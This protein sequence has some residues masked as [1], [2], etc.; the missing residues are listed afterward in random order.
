MIKRERLKVKF[1]LLLLFVIMVGIIILFRAPYF[2]CN[3]KS[4]KNISKEYIE[5][6]YKFK[7]RF[8][9]GYIMD[10]LT[11]TTILW[12]T[13]MKRIRLVLSLKLTMGITES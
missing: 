2:S 13:M 4:A 10:L 3:M 12:G 5:K 9:G 6:Q 7:A 11:L 8:T 1:V